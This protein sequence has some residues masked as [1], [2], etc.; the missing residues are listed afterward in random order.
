[1]CQL[2]AIQ[3]GG[4]RFM[5][6]IK[7]TSAFL[8]LIAFAALPFTGYQAIKLIEVAQVRNFVGNIFAFGYLLIL[9]NTI[10]GVTKS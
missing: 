10:N 8:T 7:L 2:D 9:F 4:D 1:V 5:K 3:L 6:K